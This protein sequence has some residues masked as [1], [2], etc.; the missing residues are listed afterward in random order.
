MYLAVVL[1]GLNLRPFLTGVAPLASD[2]HAATGLS[3]QGMSLFASLSMAAMGLCAFLG[4]VIQRRIAEDRWIII[5]ALSALSLFSGW[6]MLTDSGSVLIAS[7]TLCALCVALI[8]AVFPRRIKAHFL[9]RTPFAMGLFSACLMGGGA[10]G[11]QLSPLIAEASGNWRLGLGWMAPF[12]AMAAAVSVFHLPANGGGPG[13]TLGLRDLVSRPRAWLLMVGFGI[14]NGSYASIVAWLAPYYQRMGWGSTDSGGLLA[15]LAACQ[16]IA[17]LAIPMLAS[18]GL[19]RR[20]WIVLSLGLQILGF[21]GLAFAPDLH[22]ALW[23]IVIGIGMGGAFALFMIVALDHLEN[24]VDAGAL[25]AFMQGGGFLI[26]GLFPW[27]VAA[28]GE[29]AGD[30]SSGWLVHVGAIGLVAVMACRFR[31]EGYALALRG[32]RRQ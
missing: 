3:D 22:P 20:P 15:V 21:C 11:A 32:I 14:V 27:I 7:T 6:R 8:Q 4:P 18:R 5:G 17:A 26:A 28:L 9:G 2:I 30:L 31:P 12:A 19:D 1:I 25:S 10:V 23:A 24:P 13:G 16:A 29:R